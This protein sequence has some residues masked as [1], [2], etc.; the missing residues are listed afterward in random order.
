MTA[1]DE[2]DDAPVLFSERECETNEQQSLSSSL[3]SD[4]ARI[5]KTWKRE[6]QKWIQCYFRHK[7]C[8]VKMRTMACSRTETPV[9]TR[10]LTTRL[11]AQSTISALS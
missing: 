10:T 8:E 11:Y 9:M 6:K 2:R 7:R 5:A 4:Q 1:E 3:L